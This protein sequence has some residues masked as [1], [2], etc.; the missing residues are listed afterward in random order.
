M[1]EYIRT[2]TVS[3]DTIDLFLKDGWEFLETTKES[4]D[5]NEQ[6]IYH[7]GL[8]ARVLVH[9]LIEILSVYENFGLKEELFKC[10]LD[11]N[12]EVKKN[13]TPDSDQS[14]I[15]TEHTHFI[16]KYESIVYGRNPYFIRKHTP[17]QSVATDKNRNEE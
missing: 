14:L 13:M 11:L 1:V 8:P 5:G 16:S 12:M 9:Q 7:I 2:A 10:I 17:S 6:I 15:T 3:S 4:A